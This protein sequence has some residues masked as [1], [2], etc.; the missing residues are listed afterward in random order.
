VGVEVMDSESNSGEKKNYGNFMPLK[1]RLV[2]YFL[3]MFG[4]E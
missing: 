3:N 2:I 1:R 4:Y